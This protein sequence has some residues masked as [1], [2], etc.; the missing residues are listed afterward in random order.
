[1][2]LKVKKLFKSFNIYDLLV[3]TFVIILFDIFVLISDKMTEP[4]QLNNINNISLEITMLPEYGFRTIFRMLISLLISLFFTFL[5]APIAAKNQYCEK[6]IIPFIDIMESIPILG[7][8]AISTITFINFFPNN[9][10]GPELAAIFVIF[11]SQVWNMILSLYQSL[12]NLP[13]ELDNV[14]E[15]FL[16]SKWK[17]FWRIEIPYALPNLIWNIMISMS[18]SWFFIVYSEA[19]SIANQ[20]ILLPGI[21]SYISKA[22]S[23]ANLYAIC[24]AMISMFIIIFIYDQVLCKPIL[25][26]SEKFKLKNNVEY[27]QE[28]SLFYSLFLK[29]NIFHSIK[30]LIILIRNN[31]YIFRFLKNKSKKFFFILENKKIKKI[32]A[33]FF[34]ITVY[35]ALVNILWNI[36]KFLIKN[37]EINEIF[38]VVKL[39]LI[40]NGI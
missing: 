2:I 36:V 6:I 39:G 35:Y 8:L 19:I 3:I 12:R 20:D 22:I 13:K 27:K 11:T 18:A 32:I 21:G 5:I 28:K 24:Y 17:K 15:V 1:M 7:F 37:I 9:I 25:A 23:E 34:N 10:L 14:S 38:Y 29:S 30:N 31:I 33:L 26:W 16:L 4:F 40:T